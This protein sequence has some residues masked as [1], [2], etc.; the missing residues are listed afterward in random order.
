MTRAQDREGPDPQRVRERVFERTVGKRPVVERVLCSLFAG[1]HVLLDDAPGVGKTFV[2][3]VVAG[4]LGLRAQR[5]QG[6][7][8]LLPADV[9]VDGDTQEPFTVLATENPL[10]SERAVRPPTSRLDRFLFRL[11][12][13][14][15]EQAAEE[16]QTAEAL[17]RRAR[18][19]PGS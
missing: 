12:V 13:G 10:H 6:T 14:H 16:L 17:P 7:P 3:K 19:G 4:A 2:L 5:I 9:T 8:D 1:G 11:S 18:R 15:P